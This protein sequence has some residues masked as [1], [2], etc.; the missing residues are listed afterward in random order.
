M[1]TA[2]DRFAIYE[3]IGLYGYIVDERQ[4]TRLD[5]VFTE[6][7]VYDVT[8]FGSGVVRGVEGVRAMW[9]N[10]ETRHPVSHN[11]CNIMVHETPEGEVRAICKGLGLGRK[12]RVGG[13][14]YYDR[15]QRTPRGW[16]IAERICVRRDPDGPYDPTMFAKYFP[17]GFAT[18]SVA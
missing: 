1:L 12:G 16:R 6:D 4:M 9:T 11:M 18:P 8:S 5:E 13:V 7:V 2:E 14:T 10:P 3:L 17:P 15:M